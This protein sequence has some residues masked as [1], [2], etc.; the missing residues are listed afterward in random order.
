MIYFNLLVLFVF[1]S[2]IVVVFVWK[3]CDK[4]M[5]QHEKAIVAQFCIVKIKGMIC[6]WSIL[7]HIRTLSCSEEQRND[8]FPKNLLHREHF[9]N[10]KNKEMIC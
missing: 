10:V 5:N 3:V 9:Y 6:S 8:L 4:Q 2:L 7:M 1:S